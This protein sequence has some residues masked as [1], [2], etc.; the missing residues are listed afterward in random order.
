M[1]LTHAHVDHTGFAEQARVQVGATV[2]AHEAE[3]ELMRHRY[4]MAQHERHPLLYVGNAAT[5]RAMAAM[6][7][8]AAFRGRPIREFETFGAGDVLDRVPGSPRVV[9]TPGHT[10]GHSALHLP[11]RDVIFTGDALVTRNP[12]TGA[13]G[14]QLVARAATADSMRALESLDRIAETGAGLLLTGHGEPW[15]RGAAEAARLARAAGVS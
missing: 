10:F 5:R 6:L 2:Y 14:P 4:R 1:V 8:T 11:D 12:Y 13:T 7:A 15:A 3:G 9:F